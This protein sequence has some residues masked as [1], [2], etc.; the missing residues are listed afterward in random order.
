MKDDLFAEERSSQELVL[1][2]LNRISS[3]KSEKFVHP[4][5]D[6]AVFCALH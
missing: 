5:F 4:S 6:G 1:T 2:L 3:R